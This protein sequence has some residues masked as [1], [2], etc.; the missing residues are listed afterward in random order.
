MGLANGSWQVEPVDGATA[1]YWGLDKEVG[2]GRGKGRGR[3]RVGG[4][5]QY[6]GRP[7][8]LLFVLR[9]HPNA[10]VCDIYVVKLLFRNTLPRRS[11]ENLSQG[12]LDE[13]R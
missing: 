12:R 7:L 4:R 5:W 13:E 6:N 3:G 2:R 10:A 1:G 11:F 8:W 9:V